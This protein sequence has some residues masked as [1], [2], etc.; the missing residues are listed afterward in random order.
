MPDTPQ[1]IPTRSCWPRGWRRLRL[2]RLCAAGPCADWAPAR[3]RASHDRRAVG[4]GAESRAA[5]SS[6]AIVWSKP[7][8]RPS[9]R[10]IV[11]ESPTALA[12]E[13]GY[14]ANY[15]F[16]QGWHK[17][18]AVYRAATATPT[19]TQRRRNNRHE[20][21]PRRR[22]GR[23]R[24]H[25][26]RAEGRVAVP[27]RGYPDWPS[28]CPGPAAVPVLP[29]GRRWTAMMRRAGRERPPPRRRG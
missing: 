7:T 2:Q 16:S 19:A 9:R 4:W 12:K 15:P 14:Y 24:P 10:F 28:S 25:A 22:R 17:E 23:V 18:R 26:A 5:K 11:G 8:A 6:V 13:Y 21:V 27:V 29:V 3:H 20:L 1:T